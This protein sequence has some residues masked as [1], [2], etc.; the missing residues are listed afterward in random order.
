ME[1]ANLMIGDVPNEEIKKAL[2]DI[3]DNK[4]LGPDVN[5]TL[6]FLVPKILTPQKVS[7]FRPIAC[8]NVIY[9]CIS[10]I[11][12]NRIKSTLNQII[13]DNQSA[14]VLGR[15]ITDNILLTQELF[16]GFQGRMVKWIMTC[17]ASLKFTIC[18]NG[19]RC[20]YFKGGRGLRQGDLISPYI[21][22]L[23]ME[24]LNLLLKEEIRKDKKFK[25]HFRCRQLKITHLC[26][27]DDLIMLCHGDK[28]SVST[29][30]RALDKVSSV[31]GLNPNLGKCTMFCGSLDNDTKEEISSIFLS[32]KENFQ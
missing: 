27:V 1:E 11:L 2:F 13:D 20:G 32:R 10:K 21:F 30:K 16:K 12:T 15:A 4:A 26:F 22:T 17:I 6:I 29:L 25:Y 24:M 14:F 9:K 28:N 3:D 7:D 23:V 19:E 5:G 8:C 31:S 18:V